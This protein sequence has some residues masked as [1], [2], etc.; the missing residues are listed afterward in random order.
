MKGVN[1]M[2][3]RLLENI[4]QKLID[5]I[6][7]VGARDGVTKATIKRVS[8]LCGVTHTVLLKRF[9]STRGSWDAAAEYVDTRGMETMKTFFE[10]SSDKREIWDLMLDYFLEK[11]NEALYY[12][13]YINTVG[14]DPTENNARNVEYLHYAKIFLGENCAFSDRKYLMLWDYITT[15]QFYYAEK[16]IHGYLTDD[17][18]TR[19]MIR[20]IVFKGID[21]I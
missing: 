6:I 4:D 5:A 9:G 16:I 10:R 7:E 21:N 8:A 19:A 3:Y 2:S 13:S 15:M 20:D 11:R 17:E 1:A 18:A 12:T 14:F